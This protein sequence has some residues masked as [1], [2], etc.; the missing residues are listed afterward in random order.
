MTDISNKKSYFFFGFLI[1]LKREAFLSKGKN[2]LQLAASLEPTEDLRPEGRRVDWQ[3][4]RA[5]SAVNQLV[6][7]TGFLVG[8]RV[9]LRGLRRVLLWNGVWLQW[10][11][12]R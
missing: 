3:R 6:H 7:I 5:A 2:T 12:G 11:R 8:H 4:M 1:P 9:P 10:Q